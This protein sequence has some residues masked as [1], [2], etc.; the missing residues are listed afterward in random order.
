[1]RRQA[2]SSN[3]EQSRVLITG[4]SQGIGL[5]I[6]R[7]FVDAGATVIISG[8]DGDRLAEAQAVLAAGGGLV[9]AVRGDVATRSGCHDL[10]EAT[11]SLVGG[12]DVLCANAGVYP[13]CTID[14][15]GDDS[16][17]DV[18]ATN[19][20]GTIYAVQAF[21]SALVSAPHGRVVV[22]SSITGH[23]TGYPGLSVYGASK[24]AQVGFVRSAALELAPFGVTV[25]AIC[26]GSIHT[27]GLAGLGEDA[28]AM[29]RR[30][31]PLGRLG[32]PY[33]IG[34]LA[35]FLASPT[36]GFI[37]GQA[38]VV[39]GGQTLPELPAE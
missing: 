23:T 17:D 33:D 2:L 16:V 30:S 21:R 8:R 13:E 18:L 37:T 3:I 10:A 7:A 9:H 24:A 34:A 1:M 26:P 38:I 20:K 31:I 4:G 28:M 35:V 36:A 29:M 39:D 14:Q 22:T 11:L 19:L 27:E 6:A 5:G 25:N 32:D 12:L 15:L